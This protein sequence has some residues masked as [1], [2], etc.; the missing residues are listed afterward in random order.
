MHYI[1]QNTNNKRIQG[2]HRS[3]GKAAWA[4]QAQDLPTKTLGPTYIHT[5]NIHIKFFVQQ[6]P[7]GSCDILKYFQEVATLKTATSQ[8]TKNS[9]SIK[10]VFCQFFFVVAVANLQNCR[11][12]NKSSQ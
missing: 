12:Q 1:L 11:L 9:R 3:S 6:K 8:D 7:A 10:E 2:Q 5:Y 4:R